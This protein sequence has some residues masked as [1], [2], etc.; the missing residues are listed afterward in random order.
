MGNQPL[1]IA[2]AVSVITNEIAKRPAWQKDQPFK[3]PSDLYIAARNEMAAI[4]KKR[5][6]PLPRSKTVKADNFLLY[7]AVIVSD[8]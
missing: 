8:G 5:G 4:M 7:G 2:P 1:L 6:F 3:V